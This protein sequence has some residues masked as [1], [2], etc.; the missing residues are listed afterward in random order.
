MGKSNNILMENL[1]NMDLA[2]ELFREYQDFLNEDLC[3]QN[4]EAELTTL[5]GKYTRPDGE[6]LLATVNKEIAGIVARRRIDAD[7][8]EMKRL[9][10][11]PQFRGLGIGRNLAELCVKNAKQDRE[12]PCLRIDARIQ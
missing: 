11:R 8:C 10:I 7:R 12:R 3:F 6:I 9:Y 5:P 1:E 2:R 4:F